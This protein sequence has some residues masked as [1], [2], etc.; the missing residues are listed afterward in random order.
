MAAAVLGR[1]ARRQLVELDHHS[2]VRSQ[3]R[4]L[5]G[6]VHRAHDTPFGRAHDFERIR[7]PSDFQRLVP[8]RLPM[9]LS[10][11]Q[12]AQ[13]CASNQKA[14]LTALGLAGQVRRDGTPTP[15]HVVVRVRDE[16]LIPCFASSLPFFLRPLVRFIAGDDPDADSAMS[17][18][19]AISVRA[20]WESEAPIALED[21]RFGQFRLLAD[22]GVFF[23]FVP[24][25]ELGRPHP[26]RLTV[27]E[28]EAGAIYRIAVTSA[29]GAWAC[30]TD[31][32]VGI[33]RCD[34]P[35][36]IPFSSL[37]VSPFPGRPVPTRPPHRQIAGTRAVRPETLVHSPWSTPVDQG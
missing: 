11:R 17:L 23:E 29:A 19:S 8:L 32:T 31:V 21:P 35:L 4:I 1:I 9:E 7:T 30:L 34:P 33:E 13:A 37:R 10:V 28:I 36:M 12:N 14:A 15:V 26:I 25:E 5:R 24:A 3:R 6:L 16:N 18:S 2:V 27:G 22:H 20:I